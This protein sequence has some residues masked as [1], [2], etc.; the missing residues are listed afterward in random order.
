MSD[1]TDHRIGVVVV[2]D[3]ELAARLREETARHWKRLLTIGILCEL[4]GIYSIF[5]PIVA[6]ISV[7]VLVGWV[8]LVGGVVQLGHMLRRELAWA[9][10]VAWRLLVAVLTIVAGAW[11]LLA[12]L[13]GAITLTVVLV[14][15][16]W[17]I[18]VTRLLAW[19]R[20]RGVERSWINGL[21]GALSV[22]LGVFIWADLP[23]SATWAIGLLV[24]IELLFAGA[25][26]V[27][28]ALAGRQLARSR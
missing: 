2:D 16:F 11:I 26:L 9:W 18:G 19:W 23:S 13:T 20:M 22:L 5:V 17:A 21:N 14:A 28:A 8:L 3:G 10:D 1:I 12:P 4:V 7:T 6:S 25:G 15:W 27:M 24:G